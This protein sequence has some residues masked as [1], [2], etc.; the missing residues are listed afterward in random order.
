MLSN[1]LYI[2]YDGIL[3]PL[4]QS[5]VL[6]YLERLSDKRTIYL[7]S[8]EK[9]SDKKNKSLYTKI[10][11]RINESNI[12]WHPL[13]YYKNPIVLSTL[14]GIFHATVLS[15]WIVFKYDIKIIH[16]RSY[17]SSISALV[18]K[19]FCDIQYIFDMR[20][21][22]A[23]ERVDGG[24]WRK[25]SYLYYMTKFF[26]RSFLL[27]ADVVVSLTH[28]AVYEMKSFSYLKKDIP[29][30]KVITTCTNLELFKLKSNSDGALR[31]NKP[32]TVGYVG[33]IGVWYLFEE[34][35]DYYKLIQEV[36]PDA[37]LH[38]INKGGHTYI[39]ECLNNSGI[40]KGSVL[41]ETRDHLDVAHAM[42]SMD[43]GIFMIKPLYSKIASMPTKLGEFLGCGVPC[44]CNNG[45]GDM[46]DIINDRGVGVVLDSF[47]TDEKKESILHLLKLIKDPLIKNR[48]RETAL[49]YFSLEDGVNSYNNIYK[50]LD[51]KL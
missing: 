19:F 23:D 39:N 36:V 2:S 8:F 42:Q 25:D 44:I 7:I 46:S 34:A 22:W 20:G 29:N 35:L 6:S 5:Q 9:S 12:K 11:V 16:A 21:F 10:S 4:G 31:Q 37:Q 40:D 3:E 45:I 30:F 15:F 38:I 26:E 27:N 49:K 14:W 51:E 48:C 24:I 43:V 1:I 32:L 41:L 50:S 47:D 18:L 17:V 33:S 28:K 13:T